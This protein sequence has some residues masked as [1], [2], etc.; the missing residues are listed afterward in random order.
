MWG[1]SSLTRGRECDRVMSWVWQSCFIFRDRIDA[2]L[3]EWIVSTL[4]PYCGGGGNDLGEYFFRY[5]GV[6]LAG[7]TPSHNGTRIQVDN[8][9]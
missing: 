2:P 5:A 1:L 4:Y 9:M 7:Y 3:S 8:T 6:R